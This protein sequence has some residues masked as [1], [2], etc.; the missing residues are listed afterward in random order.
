MRA[1]FEETRNGRRI[2]FGVAAPEAVA[3][4]AA[5]LDLQR[6]AL[7]VSPRGSADA[8][9]YLDALGP[10][11]AGV[12]ALARQ[13]VPIEIVRAAAAELATLRADSIV[14]VGGGSPIGLGKALRLEAELSRGF[15]AVPTTYAGSEMTSIY[16]IREGGAKRVG[17]DPRVAPDVVVYDPSLLAALPTSIAIPSLFNALAHAVDALYVPGGA[18]ALFERAE[19]AITAIGRA[20]EDPTACDEALYGAYL[21]ASILGGDGGSTGMALH[22]KLAHVVAGTYELPHAPTHAVLLPHVIA[23]NHRAAPEVTALCARALRCAAPATHLYD[24]AAAAGLPLS[25]EALGLTRAQAL[26]AAATTAL[27]TYA[28][29]F[30]P[31]EDELAEL[32]TRAWRGA[33]PA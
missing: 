26:E 11:G 7:V 18:D 10:R 1:P 12:I 5:D 2:L 6:A 17:T 25:L 15:I 19:V 14:A 24:R 31:T 22:H 21:A 3:R 27:S 20:L 28:N 4:A 13:H 8:G 23:F 16:G 33:R 32:L 29:A 30:A 9:P